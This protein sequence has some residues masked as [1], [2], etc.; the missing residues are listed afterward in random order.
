DLWR[1]LSPHVRPAGFIAADVLRIEAGFPLFTNEFALPVTPVE[2]GLARFHRCDVT[3][4]RPVVLISF[5]AEAEALS[6]PWRPRRAPQRPVRPGDIAVTSACDSIV[7]GGVLGLGYVLADTPAGM[8]LHDPDAVFRNIRRAA[9]PFYDTG[10]R[11]PRAPW[12]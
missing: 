9:M 7:A 12:R 1:A 10:K 3:H 2:A 5:C 6:W 4:E 11:R 8:P